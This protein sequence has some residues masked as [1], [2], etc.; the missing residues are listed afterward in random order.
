MGYRRSFIRKLIIKE[1]VS[2]NLIGWVAGT[3]FSMGVIELLNYF[4]Y[5]PKGTPMGLISVQSM[6]YTLI[7][8]LMVVCFSLLP[9]LTKL[10]KQ[11]AITIIE[12]RD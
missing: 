7:I 6:L 9:I 1:V 10:R 4:I 8:P 11:D 12:R 5:L 2:L 3:L